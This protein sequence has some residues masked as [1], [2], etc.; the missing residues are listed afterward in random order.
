[1][2]TGAVVTICP[3]SV[4]K[5]SIPVAVAEL[6]F[7]N[8][9]WA[10]SFTTGKN[11]LEIAREINGTDSLTP[12]PETAAAASRSAFVLWMRIVDI[13]AVV[14]NKLDTALIID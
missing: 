5:V 14:P 6:G 10:A 3:S 8:W 11:A 7:I 12:F 2:F 9:N 13:A 4:R 1:M